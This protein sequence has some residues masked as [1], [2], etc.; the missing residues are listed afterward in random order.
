[1]ISPALAY[2]LNAGFVPVREAAEA[3]CS[4]VGRVSYNLEYGT[5][6]AGD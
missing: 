3:A 5:D 4:Y 6:M 2:R 1:M